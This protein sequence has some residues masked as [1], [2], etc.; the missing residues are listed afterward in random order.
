MLN[1]K[2]CKGQSVNEAV[3][4]RPAGRGYPVA[5]R[6]QLD[7]AAPAT[8]AKRNIPSTS[9]AEGYVGW[10]EDSDSEAFGGDGNFAEW[11]SDDEACFGVL[12]GL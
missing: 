7:H 10:F 4:N 12:V 1:Y 8:G 3:S 11:G 2:V 9:Q 5:R 6:V